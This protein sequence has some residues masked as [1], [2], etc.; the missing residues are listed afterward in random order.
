MLVLLMSAS[1][2]YAQTPPTQQQLDI[3]LKNLAKSKEAE[4]ALRKKLADTEREMQ[5]IRERTA[6]LAERL[7]QSEAKVSAEEEKLDEVNGRLH[8]QQAQ[9]E[10]HKA[11][12]AAT[13][14]GLLRIERLPASAMFADPH[15]TQTLMR[16]AAV[17]EN[18]NQAVA[19]KA[20]RMRDDLAQLKQL[21]GQAKQRDQITRREK[22]TLSAEQKKLARELEQR[23]KLQAKLSDDHARAEAQVAELSRSSASLQELIGKLATREK[24]ATSPRSTSKIEDAQA[25]PGRMRNPVVGTIIHRFG[26]RQGDNGTYRG[27]VFKARPGAAVVAPHDGDVVFTG[28]F[29]DYGNMVLIKHS[30]GFISLVAGLGTISAQLNQRAI[31]GEPIGSMP[32]TGKSEAYVELRDRSAKPIDPTRWF[33]DVVASSAQP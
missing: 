15:E 1:A 19:K 21:R 22:I 6:A 8:A 33:A 30:N 16:T 25:L 4:S 5:A 9:Y 28:T 14:L 20:A 12:Y 7:Q 32:E 10:E 24:T 26:E 29:R 13:V 27:M 11:D 31:R 17:L 2:P 3:T 23:R 18:T